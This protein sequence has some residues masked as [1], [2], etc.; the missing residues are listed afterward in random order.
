MM[1][2]SALDRLEESG[3]GDSA[4]ADVARTGLAVSKVKIGVSIVFGVIFLIFLIILIILI[5]LSHI[6]SASNQF[7]LRPFGS[8]SGLHA[9]LATTRAIFSR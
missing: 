3:Q 2:K 4:M 6:N 7:N 5:I 9:A 1:S 8:P